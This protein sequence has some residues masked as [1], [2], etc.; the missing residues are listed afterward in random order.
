MGGCL[1]FIRTVKPLRGLNPNRTLSAFFEQIVQV[2]KTKVL[3][4]LSIDASSHAVSGTSSINKLGNQIN[5]NLLN[6]ITT[7]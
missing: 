5:V 6:N 2:K 7:L 1:H 3:F 4:T